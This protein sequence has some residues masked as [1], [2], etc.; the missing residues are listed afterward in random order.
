MKNKRTDTL[1]RWLHS[2]ASVLRRLSGAAF[3][4]KSPLSPSSPTLKQI[5]SFNDQIIDLLDFK[6]EQINGTSLA[7]ARC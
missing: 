5:S 6:K 4:A 1:I 3:T 2:T 7:M